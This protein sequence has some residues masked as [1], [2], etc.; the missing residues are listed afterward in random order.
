[1]E[2]IHLLSTFNYFGDFS[3]RQYLDTFF[4]EYNEKQ[5]LCFKKVLQ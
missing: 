4:M 2:R 3:T 5:D 1:M